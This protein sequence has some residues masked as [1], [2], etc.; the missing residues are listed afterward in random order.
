MTRKLNFC[1]IGVGRMGRKHIQAAQMLG[2]K[3]V[4]I[5]DPLEA[6]LKNASNEF[7][8]EE[9]LCFSSVT[10]MLEEK[11]PDGIVIASTAPSHC[12]YVCLSASMGVKYILCEKPM[13][14]SI[15]ECNQMIDAC[16]ESGSLLAIN[17]QMRFVEQYQ[18]IKKLSNSPEFGGLKSVI[19]S[20]SNF[21]LAMNGSHYFEMFRYITG[22]RIKQISFSM[23]EENVPNP[24]GKEFKDNSGQLFAVNEVGHRLFI[25][26][27]GD[28]GH[29]LHVM[30]GCRNGQIFVDE[31]AGFVRGVARKE[32]FRDLPTTRYAMP[33]IEKTYTLTSTADIIVSTQDVWNAMLANENY[34]DGSVGLHA[35]QTLV[36]ANISGEEGGRKVDIDSSL[37]EERLFPW[38]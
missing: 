38:A 2:F 19:V 8:L 33:E 14:V 25:E 28:L 5:F 20:A 31:L 13:A 15:Q 27:G 22:N 9:S 21:G 7:G 30:Y 12:T 34:P 29:G 3:L 36:A 1:V 26:L 11:K 18:L 35:I 4:G 10:K 23:D 17:H 6:S 37:P 32:E 16:K 24:R